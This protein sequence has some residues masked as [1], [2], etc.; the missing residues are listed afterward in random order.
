MTEAH[1]EPTLRLPQPKALITS[2][3]SP[4]FWEAFF[5]AFLLTVHPAEFAARVPDRGDGQKEEALSAVF[6][7]TLMMHRAPLKLD[8]WVPILEAPVLNRKNEYRWCDLTFTP[9]MPELEKESWKAAKT[10]SKHVRV[11]VKWLYG[12]KKRETLLKR[13]QDNTSDQHF[14]II[15]Q[16][17]QNGFQPVIPIGDIEGCSHLCCI[18]SAVKERL[19]ASGFRYK[20]FALT[21]LRV[22]GPEDV[23][24]QQ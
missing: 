16:F 15:L 14:V 7:R 9:W 24:Q 1:V 23:G 12:G 4:E 10:P 3:E 17:V 21:V 5:S 20:H 8:H 6:Q 13:A 2:M 18:Y 19:G 22:L 11:E